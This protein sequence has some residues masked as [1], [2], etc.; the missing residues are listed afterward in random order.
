MSELYSDFADR[1]DLSEC[2][3]K[4]LHCSHH[5][6]PLL[7]ESIWTD[8]ITKELCV[9][10]SPKEKFMRLLL[11]IQVLAKEYGTD[12]HC[13]PLAFLVREVE[14]R[15]CQLRFDPSPVPEALTTQLAIDVDLLIDI[16]ARMISMNERVWAT[17]G[18][19]WHLIKSVIQLVSKLC[20][21]PLI[22]SARNRARVVAKAQELT[23]SCR[24]LLYPKPDT[25]HLI[26][27]LLEIEA[28]FQ[29]N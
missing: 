19:E 21:Q 4:I 26:N 2:Q 27:L 10:A 23:S 13:F 29:R 22:V 11:K 7:I 25:Q 18:N 12:G 15:S 16:Y 5:N 20:D 8:I 24:N 1:F 17:E 6:D 14:L 9:P 28:K 3:L